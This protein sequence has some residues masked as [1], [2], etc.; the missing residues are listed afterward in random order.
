M[1]PQDRV[2]LVLG[3]ARDVGDRDHHAIE[4]RVLA[5]ARR[6]HQHA[7]DQILTVGAVIDLHHRAAL[8]AR[9]GATEG[10]AARA[11]QP[12][13]LEVRAQHEAISRR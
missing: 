11:H 9:R 3:P 2:A 13:P 4:D 8:E 7:L 12:E 10:A 5:H 6:A 1:A